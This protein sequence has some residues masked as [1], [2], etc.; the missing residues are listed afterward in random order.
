VT[1]RVREL[2]APASGGVA[3]LS[4]EGYGALARVA[5]LAPGARLV[6]GRPVLVRLRVDEELLDEAVCVVGDPERVE[7]HLHGSP[8]L[9][10]A[11]VR[12][13]DGADA[14]SRDTL[15]ERAERRLAAAPCDAAA[16]ILLDQAGGALRR[17]LE[18][19]PPESTA[20]TLD[21][22]L[23]RGARLE[24]LLRPPRV[25]LGGPANA[26]KSTLFNLLAG[27]ER[28][29][30]HATAGTTR[31]AVRERVRLGD[32]AVDLVDTAGA[33][34]VPGA[35]GDAELERA[36]QRHA[37][38]A[39]AGADAVL[40]LSRGGA[41][42][43]PPAAEGA[44]TPVAIATCADEGDARADLPAVSAH[45]DPRGARETLEREIRAALGLVGPVWEPGAPAPPD[46]ETADA[47]R[48]VR[49]A[50]DPAVRVELVRRLLGR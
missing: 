21:E 1:V 23:T 24:R 5:E 9:V 17:A 4:V 12:A 31:D 11:V 46:A 6:A 34:A 13:L 14:P 40:W 2:T 49:D 22:W 20:A 29:V 19:L 28:V 50:G 41:V 37:R 36:G 7:L 35:G 32:V 48:A 18:Q 25:V 26:G 43:P 16:R 33:R 15:E 47:L 39:T 10:A 42:A 38:D 8:P 3:V 44:P 30:V 27:R 45:A